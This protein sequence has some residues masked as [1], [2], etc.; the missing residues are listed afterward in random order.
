MIQSL[1]VERFGLRVH[2]ESKDVAGY[3]LVVDKSG[4]KLA[5]LGSHI[6]EPS[7]KKAVSV[8]SKKGMVSGSTD[9]QEMSLPVLAKAISRYLDRPVIDAS[10]L[11]G[12]YTFT[13]DTYRD[14]QESPDASLRE[15]LKKLGL[16]LEPRRVQ[17]DFIII[18]TSSSVPIENVP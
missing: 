3:A 18:D 16:K 6:E 9:I 4:S 2:H 15:A 8:G 17:A 5:Q 14:P 10:G 13:I 7:D 1:L 12:T 11:D